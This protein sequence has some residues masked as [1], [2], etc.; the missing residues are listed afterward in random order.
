[1]RVWDFGR[2][3]CLAKAYGLGGI[4]AGVL[5]ATADA[6]VITVTNNNNFVSIRYQYS[7]TFQRGQEPFRERIFRGTFDPEIGRTVVAVDYDLDFSGLAMVVRGTPLRFVTAGDI[8]FDDFTF[9]ALT[10]TAGPTGG[11]GGDGGAAGE[12]INRGGGGGNAGGSPLNDGSTGADGLTARDGRSGMGNVGTAGFGNDSQDRAFLENPR[13]GRGGDG[14]DGGDAG[15]GGNSAISAGSTEA[16]GDAGDGERGAN[17]GDGSNG[18]GGTN[19]ATG[20]I[21][22][23]GGSGGAGQGGGGGGSGGGGGGGGGGGT[24]QLGVTF[25]RGGDGGDGGRGGAGGDGGDGGFGGRGG[26]IISFVAGGRIDV[27]DSVLSVRGG[28]GGRGSAGTDGSG[29]SGGDSGEDGESTSFFGSPRNGRDGGDG[30]AGGSGGDGGDG[31]TGGGGAGGTIELEAS[32]VTVDDQTLLI[33]SGGGING[34]L[35]RVLIEANAVSLA[36]DIRGRLETFSGQT[37]AN[38]FVEGDVSTPLLPDLIDGPAAAGLVDVEAEV[39]Q[40]LIDDLLAEAPDGARVG[41]QRISDTAALFGADF[42]DHDLIL[43][44]AL[45]GESLTDLSFGV[46]DE[47]LSELF[48]EPLGITTLEGL[49]LFG[50]LVPTEISRF[51]LRG[52]D[53]EVLGETWDA[54]G[55]AYVVPEPQSLALI[56]V[57]LTGLLARRRVGTNS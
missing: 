29:G 45:N 39:A 19:L 48:V 12:S 51:N 21:A 13:L 38:P 32:L 3:K 27:I 46:G 31:G 57:G 55:R 40:A 47:T 16:G 2:F 33:A 14:G 43:I 23:A 5:A 41:L 20:R 49:D 25:L 7:P 8:R 50:T 56:G 6:G 24:S 54:N 52:E 28:D 1:M 22:S 37:T 18:A 34:G 9:G 35:G 44:A 10:E 26:G 36:G 30:G 15:T 42:T 17:G 11:T 4:A 53:F